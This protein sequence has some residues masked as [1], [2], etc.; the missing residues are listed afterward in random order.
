MDLQ[1]V[2]AV[3]STMI[4]SLRVELYIYEF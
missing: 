2:C 3:E 4:F 1:G